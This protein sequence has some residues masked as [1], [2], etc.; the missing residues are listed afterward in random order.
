MG[1][2][3][4]NEQRIQYR[5]LTKRKPSYMTEEKIK[6]LNSLEFKFSLSE[7]MWDNWL[8]ELHD[9][10]AQHGDVDVPFKY[11]HNPALGAFVNR[12]RTE[13][14]KLQ[15]GLQTGLTHKRIGNL[16]DLGFKWAIHVSRTP[17]ETR[18]EELKKF[19]EHHGHCNVP[20]TYPKNQPLANWVFK[21]RGQH[22]L[23]QKMGYPTP[24]AK[25]HMCHM[26]TERIVML[27]SIGF[28]WDPPRRIT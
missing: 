20:S 19:K 10:Q 14:R 5:R 26:T 11:S 2:Y 13:H 28:E 3:W 8:K 1:G 23:Y 22:R 24:G 25:R 18:L 4:V 15:Q 27:D 12:Q 17:W 9:Y 7:K 6:M 21:Q 16:N